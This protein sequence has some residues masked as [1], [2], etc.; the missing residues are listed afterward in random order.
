M[1]ETQARAHL[2]QHRRDIGVCL[3]GL[4]DIKR[5]LRPASDSEPLRKRLG[6][7]LRICARLRR[8]YPGIHGP[9]TKQMELP[10]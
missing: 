10:L 7:A 5:D 8:A 2:W 1:T 9:R 3:R 6:M 4:Q